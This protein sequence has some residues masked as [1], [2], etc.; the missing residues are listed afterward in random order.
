VLVPTASSIMDLRAMGKIAELLKMVKVPAFAVL[1]AVSPQGTDADDA[2]EAIEGQFQLPVSPARL[3]QRKDF[4]RCLIDGR[5]AQE[6]ARKGVGAQ[7]V[8]RLYMWTRQ[9]LN[10]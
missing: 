7:E 5:T 6:Y 3:V 2:A 8:E 9:Q 10:M 4:E 1:N